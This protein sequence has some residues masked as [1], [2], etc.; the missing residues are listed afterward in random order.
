MGNNL[1]PIVIL[2]K[3][4]AAASPFLAAIYLVSWGLQ[5][6]NEEL[7]A[8]I[9]MKI[10]ALPMIFE[11][12]FPSY[13]EYHGS[14]IGMSYIHCAGFIIIT[15]IISINLEKVLH[16][17][18]RLKE[19]E[20][21][22]Q[23]IKQ[24]E[25]AHEQK[26]IVKKLPIENINHFYALFELKLEY[27]NPTEKDPQ[28]LAKLKKEFS[29]MIVEKLQNKYPTVKFSVS[30]KIFIYSNNFSLFN[31]ISED[32]AK[33]YKIF[34]DIDYDKSI[35][36]DLLL[37][38]WCDIKK[39]DIKKALKIMSKINELNYWN[40]IVVADKFPEKYN[41]END[42]IYEIIPLGPSRLDVQNDDGQD[43]EMDLFYIK[44]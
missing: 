2:T 12:A 40:K 11:L 37:S 27:Y 19:N 21:F 28:D 15:T 9:D 18:M 22:E 44:K 7:F 33:L 36:T 31:P 5:F 42:R 32:L 25:E 39:T 1:K 8:E 41:L 34:Y 26:K 3:I 13:I 17:K 16:R 29:R 20:K 4:W 30:D 10:G 24:M 23:K 14:Q 6:G 43:I 38:F 35:K